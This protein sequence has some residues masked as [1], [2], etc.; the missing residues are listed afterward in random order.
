MTL[1]FGTSTDAFAFQRGGQFSGLSRAQRQLATETLSRQ[2]LLVVTV[3]FSDGSILPW[4]RI[5][6]ASFQSIDQ[7][8]AKT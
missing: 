4:H 1:N 7:K 8:I 6:E 5:M 3:Q 2:G